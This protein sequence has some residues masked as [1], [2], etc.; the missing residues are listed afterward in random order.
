[1][2]IAVFALF[3]FGV[4]ETMVEMRGV[5]IG[6][7]TYLWSETSGIITRWKVN[8]YFD[9]R[10]GRDFLICEYKY[11]VNGKEYSSARVASYSLNRN[12]IYSIGDSVK[13]GSPHKVFFDPANPSRSVLIRGWKYANLMVGVGFAIGSFVIIFGMWKNRED[14]VDGWKNWLWLK[15]PS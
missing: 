3:I 4:M 9:S 2:V 11:V 13:E 6:H 5:L 7:E 15:F 10:G 8:H 1:M 12:D 14:I